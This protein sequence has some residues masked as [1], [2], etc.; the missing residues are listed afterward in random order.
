MRMEKEGTVIGMMDYL[1]AVHA[2]SKGVTNN[3]KE[4]S[5]VHGPAVKNR[6]I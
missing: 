6:T 3:T 4:Y 5:R 2:G 1:I